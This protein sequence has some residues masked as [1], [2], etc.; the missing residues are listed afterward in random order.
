MKTKQLPKGWREVELREITESISAGGTPRRDK[1]E[2][3]ENGTIPWVKISDMKKKY[4]SR[5]EEKITDKGLKNSST[6]LFPSGTLI[7]SIF[8]SLGTIGILE[9]DATTNQA[10]AGITPKKDIISTKYLYYCLQAEKDKILSKKSHATQDNLNLTILRNHKIPLPPLQ[11]QK[12]IVSILEKAETLKQKRG[13]SDKLTKDYLQSVF[14]EMFFNKG[15]EI[16]GLLDVFDITTGK[17]DSNAMEDNGKYPFFTC[18]QET[19]KINNYAFDC[20]ALLLAGNN[21]AGVYSVKYYNG[22]FNAYQRTYVLTLKNKNDSFRYLQFLLGRKLEELKNKSLGTNTKYL[23]LGILRDIGLIIP[24]S[25]EQQ[26]FTFIVEEVEKL[27]EKQKQSKEELKVMF[28]SLMKQA[29]NGELV[30]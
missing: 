17:L 23:T 26:K 29:F 1:K 20:E 2:Y 19:Y 18:S 5:T 3:W 8:A 21:A 11:T 7:Y 30:K 25:E 28:D 6:N 4:I 9:I 10:I 14:Y 27:K 15:Y 16:K 24:P 13:E 12:V 22:K